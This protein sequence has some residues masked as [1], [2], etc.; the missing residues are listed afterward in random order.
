M[1]LLKIIGAI[2]LIFFILVLAIGAICEV[3][4]EKYMK[5]GENNGS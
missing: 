4:E 5:A 1:V 3:Y 2:V